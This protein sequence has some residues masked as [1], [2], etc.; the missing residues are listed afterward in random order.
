MKTYNKS[1]SICLFYHNNSGRLIFMSNQTSNNNKRIA[2]NTLLLYFRMLVTM[3]VI[4]FTSRVVLAA[5]GVNDYGIYN[6]VGGF[7][8]MFAIVSQA[9]TTA[10]QRFLSF[11]IGKG[12]NGKI[13][14]LF[15]TAV[16]IH[17]FIAIFVLV[18]AETAGLWFLNNKMVFASSRY[19]AANWVYQFSI[20]TFIVN[21]ISVPYNASLV[22]YEKMNAF[23]YVSIIEVILK[24]LIV[25]ALFITGI[26]KL[27]MYSFLLCLVAFSIRL[28]YGIYVKKHFPECRCEWRINKYFR[29]KMF[30][31]VSWN[32]IGSIAFI[33]KEQGINVVLNLF[34]GSSVNAAKGVTSQVMGALTSFTGG[35]TTALNPQIIKLYSSGQKEQMFKLVFRGSKFSYLLIYTLSLPVF[36]EAP[37]LLK[38]WLVEVP[39]YTIVFLR[40]VILVSLIDSMSYALITSVHASGKVKWYQIINGS[41]LML[42]LPCVYLS[43]KLGSPPYYAFIISLIISV[44]CLFVRLLILRN[45]INF[46]IT[47]FAKEVLGRNLGVTLLSSVIPITLYLNL[48][49]GFGSAIIVVIVS[50]L[51][52]IIVD[53]VIGLTKI[54]KIR[55]SEIVSKKIKTFLPC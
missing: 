37:F 40:I 19:I 7:V 31:F 36:L 18:V 2:K 4:L 46:P 55:V 27:I 25:Y 44:L 21:I 34:F 17:I 26:D 47:T 22:A 14:D 52:T 11:E 6:V 29:K 28:I 38:L 8:A 23:A 50:L 1:K 15:S 12:N 54:E 43:L 20:L 33:L 16:L 51:I 5:L 10:T 9:M 24:L 48:S 13:T 32:M 42:T 39:N 3:C 30:S 53:Y 41:I 49:L 35:F 45:L